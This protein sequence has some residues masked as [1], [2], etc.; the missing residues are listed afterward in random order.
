MGV[1][2]SYSYV[3]GAYIC[4]PAGEQSRFSGWEAALACIERRGRFGKGDREEMED[5]G[6]EG[7]SKQQAWREWQNTMYV[8]PLSY[9]HNFRA[10][11]IPFPPLARKTSMTPSPATPNP[12][13]TSSSSVK[14]RT[15][16]SD[17]IKLDPTGD[18]T[19]DKCMQLIYDA[20]ASDSGARESLSLRN[21]R[22]MTKNNVITQQ[23]T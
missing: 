10:E 9:L 23:A 19:R 21:R 7:E 5:G 15:A 3:L 8:H 22:F 17:G 2:R 12:N 4:L 14:D 16:V 1:S 20:L 6:R 11:L 18:K 13:G